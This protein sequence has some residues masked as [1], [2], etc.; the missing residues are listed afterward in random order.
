METTI[1]GIINA[2]SPSGVQGV[3]TL[4][5]GT[6]ISTHFSSSEGFAKSD[7]GFGESLFT[8]DPFCDKP[9]CTAVFNENMKEKYDG[10]FP[11]GYKLVWLGKDHQIQPKVE[12]WLEKNK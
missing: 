11:D 12:E 3:T 2:T 10:M 1:Y 5:D 7:L 6:I 9:H 8:K 4:E